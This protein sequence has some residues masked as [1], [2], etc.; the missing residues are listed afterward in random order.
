VSIFGCLSDEPRMER[1]VRDW[2]SAAA[3][4]PQEVSSF[5]QTAL[6]FRD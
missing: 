5:A 2:S 1:H 6:P 3:S 4:D